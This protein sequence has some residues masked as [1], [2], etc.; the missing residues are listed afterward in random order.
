MP[1]AATP[2]GEK[3]GRRKRDMGVS[4]RCGCGLIT[5]S[6]A[7]RGVLGTPR[8]WWESSDA[9]LFESPVPGFGFFAD[10]VLVVP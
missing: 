3:V 1:V 5:V 4:A 10:F 9:S 2:R 8:W 6:T 7:R